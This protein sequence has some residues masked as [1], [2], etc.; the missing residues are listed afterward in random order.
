MA[1]QR[2]LQQQY[3][4]VQLLGPV[5][6]CYSISQS[7]TC[8]FAAQI[9]SALAAT[10][11]EDVDLAA[12][13]AVASDTAQVADVAVAVAGK[14][15][16]AADIVVAARIAAVEVAADAVAVIADAAVAKTTAA[17][18]AVDNNS[19]ATFDYKLGYSAEAPAAHYSV[20]DIGTSVLEDKKQVEQVLQTGMQRQKS[21]A[22]CSAWARPALLDCVGTD[23]VLGCPAELVDFE[24]AKVERENVNS[25]AF[26]HRI[27][28]VDNVVK[29]IAAVDAV[30][31]VNVL[32][33]QI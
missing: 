23:F 31:Y 11:A 33:T 14:V 26:D 18:V 32:D 5:W 28:F 24:K 9:V 21:A 7:V 10:A 8:Q 12:G 15:N 16:V 2:V 3:S 25:Q 19:I 4:V 17:A 13:P 30:V 29:K 1:M 27:H 6:S 22:A 20:R